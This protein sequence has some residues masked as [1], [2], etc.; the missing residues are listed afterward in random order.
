MKFNK[1]LDR[2]EF[3]KSGLVNA[4][5][6]G[7]FLDSFNRENILYNSFAESKPQ[8]KRITQFC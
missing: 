1:D 4:L 3:I 7:V 2:R 5:G 8:E 6:G